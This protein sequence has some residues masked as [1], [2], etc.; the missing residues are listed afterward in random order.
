MIVSHKNKQIEKICIKKNV[1]LKI[2][3]LVTIVS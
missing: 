2:E 3:E 1:G